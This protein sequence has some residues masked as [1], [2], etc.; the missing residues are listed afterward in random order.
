M[1]APKV[2][3]HSDLKTNEFEEMKKVDGKMTPDVQNG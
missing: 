2:F 1:E 3:D